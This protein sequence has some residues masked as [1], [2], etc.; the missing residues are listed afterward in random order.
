MPA[1]C[2][3]PRKV[4]RKKIRIAGFNLLGFMILRERGVEII[5]LKLYTHGFNSL[6]FMI[7]REEES[8]IY[9]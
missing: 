4:R 1:D 5:W 9:G 2:F 8:K 3:L 6:G 7:L